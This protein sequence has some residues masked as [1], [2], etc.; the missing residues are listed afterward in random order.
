MA[1]EAIRSDIYQFA[2]M[3][4]PWVPI[5]ER[6]AFKPLRF[7][8]DGSQWV[9]LVRIR[10]GGGIPRHRVTGGAHG[11]TLSGVW[12]DL[13]TGSVSASGSYTWE[14]PGTVHEAVV[15]SDTDMVA[16]FL[17]TGTIDY[18]DAAGEIVHRDTAATKAAALA[19]FCQSIGAEVPNLIA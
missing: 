18:L 10:A 19:S 1:Q 11:Y 2:E 13:V 14:P 3:A 12:R 9:N 4:L 6:A 15:D 16:L 7:A 8:N 5:S 17:V